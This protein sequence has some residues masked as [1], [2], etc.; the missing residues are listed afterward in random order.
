[1][2]LDKDASGEEPVKLVKKPTKWMT[3]SP[4]LAK[5]LQARCNGQHE[6]ERLEGSSRT[7][8]AESYPVSLVKAILN[9]VHQTKRMKMNANMAKDPLHMQIPA[10]FWQ[11]EDNIKVSCTRKSMSRHDIQPP[12]DVA[13]DSVLVRRTIDRKTGVVMSEDVRCSMDQTQLH[14]AFKGESP[15]EVLTVF[16]SWEETPTVHA[17]S[18]VSHPGD[19]TRYDAISAELLQQYSQNIRLIPRSTYRKA[20]GEGVRTITYGSGKSGK[21]VT[22]ITESVNHGPTL[23]LCHRLATTMPSPF[24][25]LS[26]TV[27]L[28]TDGEEL[29]PRKDVQNHRLHQNATISMGNW[30]GGV[31]QILEDDKWINCDSKDKWVFLNARETFHRVTEV[32]GYRLSVIYHTPQ[33]LHRLSSEDWDILRDTG[34]PVDAVWEQGM[35]NQDE[36]DDES[37]LENKVN[38]VVQ[39]VDTPKTLSRQTSAE[40]AQGPLVEL[41]DSLDIPWSSLRPTMQ[42]IL[43][44]SD[45]VW[46]GTN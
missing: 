46:H 3:N 35:T 17:M 45:L 32:T 23:T 22:L 42:A 44:L 5:L 6:H 13:W 2:T 37:D 38:E 39:S 8:Q 28:L 25:Y 40:E 10:M 11:C 20:I 24:P 9:K 33:H 16:F 19:K 14:R 34:F 4:I 29:S 21:H 31:L 15:K 36:S 43:W 41:D 26:V 18:V 7:K 27:V 1:M 30:K 12:I